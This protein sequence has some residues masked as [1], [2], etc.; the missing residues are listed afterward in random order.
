ME[1]ILVLIFGLLVYCGHK[2]YKSLVAK[3][4]PSEKFPV[5]YHHYLQA[6][7][8]PSKGLIVRNLFEHVFAMAREDNE[9]FKPNQLQELSNHFKYESSH[10]LVDTMDHWLNTGLPILQD[11]LGTP[12][13][14]DCSARMVGVMLLA[15][16]VYGFRTG[17]SARKYFDNYRTRHLGYK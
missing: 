17:T 11:E 1:Y 10:V 15:S 8:I 5:W 14:V 4:L 2:Y 16:C 12:V 3:K 13:V 9:V 6:P 7:D